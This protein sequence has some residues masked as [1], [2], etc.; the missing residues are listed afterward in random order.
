M[1]HFSAEPIDPARVFDLLD[2]DAA[3]SVLFHFA[4][5]KSHGVKEGI[6]RH[7]EYQACGDVDENL[8]QIAAELRER[9]H[10]TDV[11]LLRRQGIVAAGEIASL[12]AVSAPG[13]ETAFAAC[14]HGL[15]CLK[16]MP[17]IRKTEH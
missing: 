6:T 14:R 4:V 12:V 2:T 15:A 9:W 7:I 10:L 17:T 8:R 5:V 1:V 3:G 13:S 11:L 16:K